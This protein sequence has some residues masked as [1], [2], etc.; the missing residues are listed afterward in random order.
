MSLGVRS[1]TW[2]RLSGLYDR[3][4]W[5]ERAAVR[6]ALDLACA[7]PDDRLL[8]LGTGTGEV[9]R[10][11]A[12]RP[13]RP[14]GAVGV[15]A[16]AA[17]LARVPALPG[18]WTVSRGDLSALPCASD[19][20]DVAVASYVLHVLPDAALAPALAELARVL[21][22][23]GRFVTVTPV[24]PARGLLRPVAVALDAMAR[25]TLAWTGGLRAFDPRQALAEAGFRV[26]RAR[27][28]QRGYPSLCVLAHNPVQGRQ[29]LVRSRREAA[30]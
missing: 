29:N 8:D 17:M 30:L 7:G 14:R 22:P 20:F 11:L 21:R 5:L 12:G 2:E 4:L 28:L 1:A 13:V 10:E 15:D 23:G 19:E 9:L 24:V 18:G 26:I 6:T 25:R 27:V 16:S 3:Q